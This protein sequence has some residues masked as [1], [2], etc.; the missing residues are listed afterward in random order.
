MVR[1]I[2]TSANALLPAAQSFDFVA[3][4]DCELL[5]TEDFA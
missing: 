5:L 1:P 3:T 2:P 4:G